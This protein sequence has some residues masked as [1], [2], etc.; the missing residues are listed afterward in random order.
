MIVIPREL[1]ESLGF[2]M[3]VDIFIFL[4]KIQKVTDIDI[5]ILDAFYIEKLLMKIVRPDTVSRLEHI[6]FHATI[7]C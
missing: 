3:L 2:V 4:K 5:K 7:I 1:L 6:Y